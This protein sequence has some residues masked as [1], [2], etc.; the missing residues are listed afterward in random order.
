MGANT[1]N[2]IV[3]W[4]WQGLGIEGNEADVREANLWFSRNRSTMFDSPRII[5]E[6]LSPANLT[7]ILTRESFG[8]DVDLVSIDV[9]G[10]DYWLWEALPTHP[11][12]VVVEY[13]PIWEADQSVTVPATDDLCTT[14]TRSG[15]TVTARP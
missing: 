15:M 1:T 3:N 5:S 11:R 9:D 12:I 14:A 8:E 13:N 10:I 4:G 2:L 7:G 6:W